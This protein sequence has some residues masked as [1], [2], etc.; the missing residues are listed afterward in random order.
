MSTNLALSASDAKRLTMRV[1][2][3]RKEVSEHIL[4][5]I[6]ITIRNRARSGDRMFTYT[7]PGA[8]LTIYNT[9]IVTDMIVET[10]RYRNFRVQRQGAVLIIS[11]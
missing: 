8:T 7:C 3:H 9:E 2:D 10:L 6:Y 1:R 5:N 4:Q 11:W